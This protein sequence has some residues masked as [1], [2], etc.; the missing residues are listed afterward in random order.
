MTRIIKTISLCEQTEKLAAQKKNFSQWIR[1]KLLNEVEEK[2]RTY[3][4]IWQY[5]CGTCGWYWNVKSEEVDNFFYCRE[6]FAD[7][8]N[9]REALKGERV[10]R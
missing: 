8:C 3:F 10:K 1:A 9:N 4:P 2:S 6:M 5:Y 7:R